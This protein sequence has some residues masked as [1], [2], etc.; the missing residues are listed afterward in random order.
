MSRIWF[1]NEVRASALNTSNSLCNALAEVRSRFPIEEIIRQPST[2]SEY[3]P[4]LINE[5]LALLTPQ[6]CY[7]TLTAL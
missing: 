1:D 3:N 4:D 6:N 7:Y 5:Y 2:L